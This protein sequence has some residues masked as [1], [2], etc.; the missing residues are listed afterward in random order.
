MGLAVHVDFSLPGALCQ[1]IVNSLHVK[2]VYIEFSGI[3]IQG[4]IAFCPCF[5]PANPSRIMFTLV[6]DRLAQFVLK[7]KI[8]LT[9]PWVGPPGSG[10]LVALY[11]GVFSG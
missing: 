10:S 6:S 11:L 5:S 4:R 1:E 2:I 7:V 8:V 9:F 3:G